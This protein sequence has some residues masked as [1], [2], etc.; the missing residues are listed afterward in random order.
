MGSTLNW[1]E[2]DRRVLASLFFLGHAPGRTDRPLIYPRKP[3]DR[4]HL[5]YYGT[6]RSGKT[7]AIEYVL[8]QLA[9][10]RSAGFCYVDPHGSSYWRMASFLR[11]HDITERVLY[12]DI[13]DP[14][15]VVTYDPFDVPGQSPAYIAGNLTTAL[16][17]TLGRKAD[18]SEQPL[19]KTITDAGLQALLTLKLPWA[20]ARSLFDPSETEVKRA[21][22]A[23]LHG[24]TVLRGPADLERLSDRMEYFGPTHRR[25]ENLF[26]DD[27]LRLTWTLAGVNFRELMDDG[28]IVLVNTQP[29][30]QTEEA[31]LL[32]T[33]LLVKSLFMAA[34][35]REA[36]DDPPPFFLAI[37]EASRYLT[38]DTAHILT[39][40]AKFGLYL[41]LGMQ[42]I[43]QARREDEDTYVAIRIAVN[44]E[45]VMRLTDF[46]EKRYF[47]QRFFGNHFDFTTVKHEQ[48]QT[49]A[50]P[51]TV[52]HETE[53]YSE[54]LGPTDSASTTTL[55]SG[56]ETTTTAS[57]TTPGVRTVTGGYHTE[58]TY[59]KVR[60]PFFLTPDELEREYAKHFGVR[61][62][63]AAQRFGIAR[64]N[65]L[66]PVE[67]EV[68]QL[69]PPLYSPAEMAEYLRDVKRRQPATLP[70]VEANRR[71]DALVTEHLARLIGPPRDP[72]TAPRKPRSRKKTPTN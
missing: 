56:N 42:S 19:L 67:L 15:Y 10:D 23:Q 3:D 20:M 35:D 32:F 27:R 12:W 43:E 50:I 71:F 40:T 16:L 2:Y 65:E 41:V 6:T 52:Q 39:Q 24:P 9:R 48:V 58:Y 5:A 44:G 36:A 7:Y 30:Q 34:K 66:H 25:I 64:I 17:A 62:A 72:Y 54:P 26:K 18:T 14:E 29:K 31:T 70:L 55:P 4:P 49:A 53:S 33:R 28:W 8:Q 60:T 59:E 46:D 63:G 57:T 38:A 68:P 1:T 69:P 11:Q 22:T 51:R 45:V 61:P 37:D 21:I 13:N 47:A